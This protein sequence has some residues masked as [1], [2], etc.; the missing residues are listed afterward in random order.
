[1]KHQKA[2]TKFVGCIYNEDYKASLELGKYYRIV[3]DEKAAKHGY[4]R[5]VDESG[6]DYLYPKHYFAQ[7]EIIPDLEEAL[8]KA[9]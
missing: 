5:I 1:M 6:E 8:L 2:E 7:V 9:S 3:P 4:L